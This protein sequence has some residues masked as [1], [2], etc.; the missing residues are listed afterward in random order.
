MSDGGDWW[1]KQQND[2]VATSPE[3]WRPLADA[4]RGFDLDPAAGC[5]PTQIA[6]DRYTPADDGLACPWF[7]TV[8][9]NPPFS[10]KTPWFRRL[11]DQYWNGSVD[12]AVALSSVDPSA[13][14]F[15]EWFSTADLI[16]YHEDRDLYL[17]AGDNPTFST[18]IGVWNPTDDVR[19]VLDRMGTV[20]EPQHRVVDTRLTDFQPPTA[21]ASHGA[22]NE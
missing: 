9:L 3:L 16:G 18:M 13:E 20:V 10:D 8:W 15:H 21:A 19:D 14:W 7:G 12:R 1:Q 11:V 2:D 17:G 4:M 22:N 6:E 5:E